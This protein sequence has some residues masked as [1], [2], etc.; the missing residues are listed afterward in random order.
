MDQA[1]GQFTLE[2]NSLQRDLALLS[3]KYLKKYTDNRGRDVLFDL[4]CRQASSA[5]ILR[6]YEHG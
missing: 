4:S 2:I 5:S 3:I 1:V 6:S